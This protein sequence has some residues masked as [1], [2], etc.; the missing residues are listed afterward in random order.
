[1]TQASQPNFV[2]IYILA[3]VL[4]LLGLVGLIQGDWLSTGYVLG[5]LGLMV[6]IYGK[7]QHR[8][9]AIRLG[10][11][12]SGAGAVILLFDMMLDLLA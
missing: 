2:W 4:A 6:W 12:V 5:A 8:Q 11:I 10:L 9:D 7:R 3:G 1:M